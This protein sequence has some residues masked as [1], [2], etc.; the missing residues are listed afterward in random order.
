MIDTEKKTSR[1]LSLD[2][3]RGL[4]IALMILV[5]SPGNSTVYGFLEHSEWNG[6]T[7]ADVVFPFFIFIV[8]VSLVL[9]LTKS[10]AVGLTFKELLPKI[11]RRT[12]IIF[13]LGLFLNAFPYHFDFETLR[14]FGVLQRIAICYLVCALLF[15][16]TRITT[17]FII[18][19]TLLVGYWLLMTFIPVPG[20]GTN[21]LTPQGNLAAYVDRLI[22]SSA[23]LYG[24]FYD[25]E[26]LLSTLPA[27]ATGLIGNLAGF[28]LI[29]RR[30]PSV[31]ITG[32]VI[33]GVLCSIAGILW[34]LWFPINK[35]LWT[36]SYVLWTGGLALLILG[37]CYWL[38]DIKG[39]KKWSKPFEI[40][41]V[42]A[43]T[44]YFLHVFFIKIQ[45]MVVIPP[46]NLRSY[47]TEHLFGWAS[48]VNASLLYALSYT[49]FWLLILT[50]LYRNKIFIKI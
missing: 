1:L 7:L 31:Q 29:S 34:G 22:F 48:S 24:K 33:A 14:F 17:Q 11:L 28:W 45:I 19:I 4:T 27:I 40:F 32:M 35:S 2:V 3:F 5:N 8:G 23:H 30:K 12:F 15:L 9:S 25:P 36:S 38:I 49:L 44:A 50:V 18:L 26:G 47:L 39:W 6:C 10:K 41:G 21:N 20:Y 16:T 37:F 13:L 43:L 46:G 42:N